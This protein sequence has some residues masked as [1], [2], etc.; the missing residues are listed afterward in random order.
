MTPNT[1]GW[2]YLSQMDTQFHIFQM[3]IRHIFSYAWFSMMAFGIQ[4]R[5]LFIV[6]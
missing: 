6:E 2:A 5:K 4:E 1:T 3:D